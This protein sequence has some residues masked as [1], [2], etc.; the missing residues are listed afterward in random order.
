MNK[1]DY[2]INKGNVSK[3]KLEEVWALPVVNR[4]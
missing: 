1:A 3:Q 2:A 4:S